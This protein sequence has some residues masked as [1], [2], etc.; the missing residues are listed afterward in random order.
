VSGDKLN[1]EESSAFSENSQATLD[2]SDDMNHAVRMLMDEIEELGK[3]IEGPAG[4]KLRNGV[5]ELAKC[6]G[7]LMSWCTRNGMNMADAHQLLG[8]TESDAMET[9]D[10]VASNADGLTRSV[11]A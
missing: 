2:Q 5:G 4:D 9:Y 11:N 6:F 10:K 3:A 1:L 7:D 8:Q